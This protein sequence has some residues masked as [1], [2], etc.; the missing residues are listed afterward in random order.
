[1][2][3][4]VVLPSGRCITMKDEELNAALIG[5]TAAAGGDRGGGAA[6]G[7]DR[8][9]DR[10]ADRGADRGGGA[11]GGQTG[12]PVEPPRSGSSQLR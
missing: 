1:M 6:A 11:A 5:P 2:L 8:G 9:G 3:K 4:A 7:G 12:A 10:G